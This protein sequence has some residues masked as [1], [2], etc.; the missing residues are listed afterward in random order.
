MT[1]STF[2]TATGRRMTEFREARAAF[3]G[4]LVTAVYFVIVFANDRVPTESFFALFRNYL[5]AAFALLFAVGVFGLVFLLWKNRPKKGQEAPSPLIVIRDWA[6]EEWTE[7]RFIRILWPPMLFAMLITAFNAYKQKILAT[8]PF[9][10]D[11][12]LAE[13][14]RWM[15]F[16]QDGWIWFHDWFGSP[17]ATLLIDLSYHAW[18]VPMSIGVI[19][20]AFLGANSYRLRTQ[21]LLTYLFVWIGLGTF[22][23]F[24]LPSAGP[25]FYNP[26]V[27]PHESYADLMAIIRAHDEMLGAGGGNL[28]ALHSMDGLLRARDA[29]G[30]VIGGG[31]SAMPSVHN[32][33]AVLFALGAYRINRT[34]GYIMA[35]YAALIWVGSVYLGWHYGSD[36]I[37]SAIA[38]VIFWKVAGRIAD[39]LDRPAAERARVAPVAQPEIG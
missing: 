12:W 3:W 17:T 19:V 6:E 39:A 1:G 31:I 16:G 14:D 36:G 38:V 27:G 22:L 7:H 23:A 9:A 5:T 24:L 20:C 35:A 2:E 32:A 15:F 26:L 25:C 29:E 18:F 21:Y 4:F 11:P 10:H 8:Q 28:T 33:L 13:A 30:L 34:F 37:V